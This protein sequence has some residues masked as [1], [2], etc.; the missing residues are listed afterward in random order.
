A[1]V[2]WPEAAA[3]A[4]AQREGVAFLQPLRQHLAIRQVGLLDA[5]EAQ[6]HL[7]ARAGPAAG[8]APRRAVH[9]VDLDVHGDGGPGAH[10]LLG[11]QTAAVATRAARILAQAMPLE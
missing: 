9:A 2:R 10:H 1:F 6:R 5:G 8:E 7:V 4:R 3:A 11:A